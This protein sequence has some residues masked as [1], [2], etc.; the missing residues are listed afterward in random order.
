MASPTHAE[1]KL[2]GSLDHAAG[3]E[4]LCRVGTT[5]EGDDVMTV[6]VDARHVDRSVACAR[7]TGRNRSCLRR[8]PVR[9]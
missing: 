9:S 7:R 1:F 5:L 3:A 2:D 4:L 8:H 6:E